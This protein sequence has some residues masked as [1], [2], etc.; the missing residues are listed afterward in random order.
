MVTSGKEYKGEAR[1]EADSSPLVANQGNNGQDV[2]RAAS[3][4]ADVKSHRVESQHRKQQQYLMQKLTQLKEQEQRFSSFNRHKLQVKWRDILRKM[5]SKQLKNDVELMAMNHEREVD[6]KDALIHMMW[7]DLSDSEEQYRLALRTHQMHVDELIRLQEKRVSEMEHEFRK[8]LMQLKQHYDEEA[9]YIDQ[10]HQEQLSEIKD[11]IGELEKREYQKD[12]ELEKEFAVQSKSISSKYKNDYHVMKIDMEELAEAKRKQYQEENEEFGRPIYQSYRDFEDLRRDNDKYEEE[13]KTQMTKIRRDEENLSQWKRTWLANQREAE[14]RNQLLVSE[15]KVLK[16]HFNNMKKQMQ[17][18]RDAE[19]S[20]LKEVVKLSKNTADVLRKR[21]EKAE[22][23]I[24]SSNLNNKKE[25]DVERT[26]I[27]RDT[28]QQDLDSPSIQSPSESLIESMERIPGSSHMGIGSELQ[29]LGKFYGK[30]N[31]ILLDKAALEQEKEHLL[32]DNN[33]L[34]TMLKSYL[35]G[36]SVNEEVL[37]KEN[38]LVIVEQIRNQDGAG[39]V[40]EG[41]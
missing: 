12:Q 36:I 41:R 35:D 15:I 8:G 17:Q 14:K 39:V 18:F 26:Q 23:I 11:I 10:L 19:N 9:Q 25:T 20:K 3:L 13:I 30:L 7:R 6:R 34:R 1:I 24:S 22:R 32:S 37:N 4:V 28:D 29:Q 2:Q 21:L 40:R 38:P 27:Q 33:K 5:K 31:K 16:T